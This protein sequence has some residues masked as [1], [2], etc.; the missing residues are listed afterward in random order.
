MRR[1]LVFVAL[2]ALAICPFAAAHI[3][4]PKGYF[5]TPKQPRVRGVWVDVLFGDDQL[6]LDNTS[7]KTV[8]V[9]GYQGEPYLRF[10]PGNGIYENVRSPAT[11]VNAVR[12]GTVKVPPTA[13]AEARPRWVKIARLR[14]WYWHDHRIHWMSTVAPPVVKADPRQ[15]HH[16]FNWRVPIEVGGKRYSIFGSL[17]YRPPPIRAKGSRSKATVVAFVFLGLAVLVASAWALLEV[18]GR[19]R[20]RGPG[21]DA[22]AT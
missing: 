18:S 10:S 20:S 1:G 3:G 12:Y 6:F 4:G 13:R 16:V 2:A 14:S 19:R 15:P 17:D 7:G 8:I 11:Y 21:P 9:T 22:N 5:S